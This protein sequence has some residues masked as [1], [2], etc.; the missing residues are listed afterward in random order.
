MAEETIKQEA[1][2][3]P[4]DMNNYK[5][6]KLPK[7][8]KSGF[9]KILQRI[10][11]PLAILVFVVICFFA[12]IPFIN[13]IDTNKETTTLAEGAVK[14]YEDM[15][16]KGEKKIAVVVDNSGKET[17]RELTEGEKQKL[18]TDTHNNFLHINYAM[19]AIF[20]A[21]IILWI[22]EAIPNYLTSLIVIMMIVLTGVTS[23]KPM[24][25]SG[26]R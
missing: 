4:L 2:F 9:E 14:R 24:H 17:K 11:G 22:T 20:A 18:M 21:A 25:S 10:G 19:L 13:R 12:D 7:M 16:K 15:Y 3:D 6:E 23:E 26:T 8:Q 5:L 1:S